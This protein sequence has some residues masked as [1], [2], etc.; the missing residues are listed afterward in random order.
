MSPTNIY[1]ERH[2]FSTQTYSILICMYLFMYLLMHLHVAVFYPLPFLINQDLYSDHIE[3]REWDNGKEG[4]SFHTV[5]K[6]MK[7][8]TSVSPEVAT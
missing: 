4:G 6:K 8:E 5:A 3:A 7:E 1:I 2:I